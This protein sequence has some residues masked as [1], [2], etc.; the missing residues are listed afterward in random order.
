MDEGSTFDAPIDKVWKYLSSDQHRHPSIKL[1]NREV[2]GNTV[3]LTSERN[4]MGKTMVVKVKNTLYPPFGMVQEHIEGPLKGSRAFQYYI[5]KGG[6]TGVCVVGD[7]VMQGMN[8]EQSVRQVVLQQ[9]QTVF[10]ED[11]SNLKI[12]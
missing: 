5:P 9:A 7:Y 11:N 2:N 12:V 3:V 6:K 4:I 10:D 8:D 1:L